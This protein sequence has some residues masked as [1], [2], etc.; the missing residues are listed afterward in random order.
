MMEEILEEK[1]DRRE[2][3]ETMQ[4]LQRRL[5]VQEKVVE[6]LELRNR[7]SDD[8]HPGSRLDVPGPR[9][10]RDWQLA[11]H[12]RDGLYPIQGKQE[13]EIVYC[14]FSKDVGKN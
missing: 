13:M 6:T 1:K 9:S 2:M 3:M 7:Q 12:S 5:T 8:T 10:C 4:D 14:S 11:G